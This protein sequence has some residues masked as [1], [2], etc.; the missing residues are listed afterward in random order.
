MAKTCIKS[1]SA[2]ATS[3]NILAFPVPAPRWKYPK[4]DM[5]NPVNRRAW[6]NLMDFAIAERER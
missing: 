3:N 2:R 6:E 1:E 4:P 5:D